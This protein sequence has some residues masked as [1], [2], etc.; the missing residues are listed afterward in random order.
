MAERQESLLHR[1]YE[2][3]L[4]GESVDVTCRQ[5]VE[6]AA[7]LLDSRRVSLLLTDRRTGALR[8]AHAVGMDRSIWENRQVPFSSRVAGRVI[9]TRRELVVNRRTAWPRIDRY[10]A[11]QFVS[12]PL[13]RNDCAGREDVVGVLNVTERHDRSDYGPADVLALHQLARAT[14]FAIDATST[15]L[16]LES[17]RDSIILSLARLSEYR[18]ASTGKHLER[19]RELSLLL[20]RYLVE[21]PRVTETIDSRF[22]TDLGRAAPLHDV[23]KIAIPDRILLKRGLLTPDEFA[24]IQEHTNIGAA[25]LESVIAAGHDDSFLRMAVDIARG[26]HERYDGT[27]YPRRLSGEQ[28]PLT[29]RIV[30]L[31]D[32]Y[33]AIRTVREYK[34]ARTH[35]KAACEILKGSGGQFDP[36][37]VQAFCRLEDQFERIYNS[38][39]EQENPAPECPEAPCSRPGGRS[40]LQHVAPLGGSGASGRQSPG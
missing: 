21:D 5:A 37:L 1:F 23:G 20:A 40:N 12:V 38:M 3:I 34:P 19:V 27:G 32:S 15:R 24:M 22:L 11:P 29:A 18:H 31:A 25:T 8:F 14:A 28:I 30:C 7:A 16:K 6:T 13:I 10:A 4:T 35:R 36:I 17:A 9:A 39:M 26:H 2:Q 33:D